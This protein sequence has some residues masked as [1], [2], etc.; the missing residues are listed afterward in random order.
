[1]GDRDVPFVW[2]VFARQQLISYR[3]GRADDKILFVNYLIR[4]AAKS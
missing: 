2:L 4:I 3:A 1:M